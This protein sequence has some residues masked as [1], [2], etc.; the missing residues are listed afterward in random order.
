MEVVFEALPPCCE[1]PPACGP[2]KPKRF[3]KVFAVVY[4]I[5]ER[6]GET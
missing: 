3:A 5:N 1:I 2:V 4:S 6:A